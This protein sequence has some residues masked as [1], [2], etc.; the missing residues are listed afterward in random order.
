M[1]VA[2]L[3]FWADFA[4]LALLTELLG[5]YYL[6]SAVIAFVVGLSVNYVLSVLWVFKHRRIQS[7]IAEF[8]IF[9]LIGVSGAVVMLAS[10]WFLTEILHLH[11][12]LSKAASSVLVFA[13]NFVLR[14]YLLFRPS[15]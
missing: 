6:V 13:V 5:L 14:K 12:L 1:A 8:V 7:G 10:M 4:T 9:C 3:G 2:P 11:Y 15:S